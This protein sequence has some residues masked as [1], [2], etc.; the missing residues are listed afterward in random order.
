V[1]AA[2]A[3]AGPQ[4]QQSQQQQQQQQQPRA[5]RGA[6]APPAPGAFF[7]DP[8]A[9]AHVSPGGPGPL[10]A[11]RRLA[12]G[13]AHGWA[14][15]A[16]IDDAARHALSGS[17]ARFSLPAIALRVRD[18]AGDAAAAGSAALAGALRGARGG[19]GGAAEGK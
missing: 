11:A 7:V 1:P 14:F 2:A 4:S 18:L 3:A 16:W 15:D 12:W 19:G 6:A 9:G 17:N 13:G 10:L 5:R 8:I